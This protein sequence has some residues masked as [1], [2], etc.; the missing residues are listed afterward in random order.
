MRR[1]VFAAGPP[2]SGEDGRG[3]IVCKDAL[4][5]DGVASVW[6]WRKAVSC[7]ERADELRPLPLV[8]K[9]LSSID[10]LKSGGTFNKK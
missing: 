7:P 10:L 5:R 9:A 8:G 3:E 1:A 4:I 6:A 2:M